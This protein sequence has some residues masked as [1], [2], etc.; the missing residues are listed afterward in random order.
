VE[1]EAALKTFEPDERA[2]ASDSGRTRSVKRALSLIDVIGDQHQGIGVSEL[3]SQVELPLS[4]VHRLLTTLIDAGFVTQNSETAK[5]QLGI[6]AFQIGRAYL[7]QTRLLDVARPAMRELAT[8]ANETVNLAVRDGF[9]AVYVDQIESSQILKL[10]TQIGSRVSL[11]CTGVGK[12]FLAGFSK[13][14]LDDYVEKTDLIPRTPNTISEP[15]LLSSHLEKIRRRHFAVDDEEFEIGV[16][17]VAAPIHN[18]QQEVVAAISV[19]G[20]TQRVTVN[21]IEPLADLVTAKAEAI[22]TRLGFSA[23]ESPVFS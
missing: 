2:P 7:H 1:S 19:S 21:E 23:C 12:V 17:C 10:F 3:S 5:Y 16:R 9:S 18:H 11:Y 14:L 22:S 4:T 13:S 6:K 8:E 20:P 15:K